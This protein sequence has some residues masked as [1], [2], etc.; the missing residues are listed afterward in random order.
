MGT[1]VVIDYPNE[2]TAFEVRGKLADLTKQQLLE[3]E[4]AVVVVRGQD[5]KAKIKQG[6]SL[7]GAGALG[8]SFWGL[9]IGALFFMPWLGMA[10]GAVTGALS[11][12]FA[13][14]GIDD[15]FIKQ[16]TETIQPGH[17]AVFM[18]VREATVDRVLEELT[19]FGGTVIRTNL[20]AEQEKAL[21]E[22]FGGE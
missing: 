6:T 2:Q 8:G 9:L 14:I 20:N 17:S 15:K 19:K 21:K 13:D 12:K 18:L 7:T 5:G 10:V 22:A 16:V 4:D 1:L 11:G 3:L